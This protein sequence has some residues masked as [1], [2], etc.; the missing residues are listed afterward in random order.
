MATAA[1][2]SLTGMASAGVIVLGPSL[3]AEGMPCGEYVLAAQFETGDS[4][5]PVSVQSAQTHVRLAS[6]AP[7]VPR[8]GAPAESTP[9]E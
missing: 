8:V 4:V 6:P 7:V 9:T 1:L 3:S 2:D 5:T